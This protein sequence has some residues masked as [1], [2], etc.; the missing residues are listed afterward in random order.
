M[1]KQLAQGPAHT[2]VGVRRGTRRSNKKIIK[3]DVSKED[4]LVNG[5]N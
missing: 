2:P 1:L 5:T 4:L 3:I